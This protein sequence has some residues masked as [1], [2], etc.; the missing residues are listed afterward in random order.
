MLTRKQTRDAIVNNRCTTPNCE[1][2]QVSRIHTLC[3]GCSGTMNT[4]LQRSNLVDRIMHELN[5]QSATQHHVE[6]LKSIARIYSRITIQMIISHYVRIS[7]E[8]TRPIL[9]T[10]KQMAEVRNR[11]R[12][13]II[14]WDNTNHQSIIDAITLAFCYEPWRLIK[15]PTQF[16]FCRVAI[17]YFGNFGE[18][19]SDEMYVHRMLTN[20]IRVMR[21]RDSLG[22]DLLTFNLSK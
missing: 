6:R 13:H 16:A 22:R 10:A 19:P 3:S 21:Y 4:V 2:Y 17:C 18:I 20:Y 14:F 7:N 1:F 12:K 8:S 9:F 11:I 15:E 5:M